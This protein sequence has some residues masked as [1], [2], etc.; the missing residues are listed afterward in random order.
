MILQKYDGSIH[1]VKVET[2]EIY[3]LKKDC[4]KNSVFL[5]Y[6]F[7]NEKYFQSNLDKKKNFID[8]LNDPKIY[9]FTE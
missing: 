5:S 3:M 7:K 9:K 8:N 2:I 4:F 1:E 6:E